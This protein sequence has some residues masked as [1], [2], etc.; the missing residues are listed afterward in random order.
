MHYVGGNAAR[1]TV[2][3][4]VRRPLRRACDVWYGK[5][6]WR[7]LPGWAAKVLRIRFD[8]TAEGSAHE[9]RCGP[10]VEGGQSGRGGWLA[11]G[12]VRMPMCVVHAD[13]TCYLGL[14]H[15]L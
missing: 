15:S 3:D 6:L 7:R 9:E 2:S 12:V 10:D 8:L 13:D 1:T 4:D 11:R 5:M 14:F